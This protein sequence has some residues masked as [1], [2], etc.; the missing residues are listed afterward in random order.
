MTNAGTAHWP[1]GTRTCATATGTSRT[2][3]TPSRGKTGAQ[4]RAEI[5]ASADHL[6][7]APLAT[8]RTHQILPAAAPSAGLTAVKVYAAWR[9]A[10]GFA[11]G[12]YW[13]DL[14]A[15]QPCAAIPGADG[16]H[17]VALVID[18]DQHRPPAEYCRVML[19]RLREHYHARA[20]AR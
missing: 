9:A 18:E 6:G 10:F 13:P 17:T 20:R 15:S 11:Q 8:P 14:R 3:A 19:S 1:C 7:L 2:P 5:R 12:R 16:I 4:R